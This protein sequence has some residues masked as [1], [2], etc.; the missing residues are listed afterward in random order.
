VGRTAADIVNIVGVALV[1]GLLLRYGAETRQLIVTT[2]GQL[3]D[4]YATISLQNV[5]AR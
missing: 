4:I 1:L 5:N 3:R 2:G